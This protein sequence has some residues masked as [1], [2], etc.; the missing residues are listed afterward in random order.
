M[1]IQYLCDTRTRRA[2]IVVIGPFNKSDVLDCVQQHR[3]DG[4]WGYG[5]L[6][7]LRYMTGQPTMEALREFAHAVERRPA[8]PP[9]GPVAILAVDPAMY[10]G[11]CTYAAMTKTQASIEVFRDHDE[12]HAWLSEQN[13]PR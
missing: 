7:D 3:A 2:V 1:P 6:Y 9:R 8:E 12:A 10:R 4:A 13:A 11:A 5:L